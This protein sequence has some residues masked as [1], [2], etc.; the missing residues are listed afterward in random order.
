MTN[1]KTKLE[2][3]M[4]LAFEACN[5]KVRERFNSWL[6]EEGIDI[7][8]NQWQVLKE[9]YQS[10]GIIQRKLAS[11]ISKETASVSRMCNKLEKKGF[12]IK[13][14]ADNN[15]K[16]M[17]LYLTPEGYD[18]TERINKQAS[19]IMQNLFNGIYDREKNLVQDILTRILK[20]F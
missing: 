13:K 17:K 7:N 20:N 10:Q 1:R 12:I 8:Y 19:R 5:K 9:V 11:N 6:S 2:E 3:K 15:K 16:A 14:P 18:L 4:L